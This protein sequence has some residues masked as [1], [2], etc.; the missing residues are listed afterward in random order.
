MKSFER[1]LLLSYSGSGG[2]F[3]RATS[4]A[5]FELDRRYDES[6]RHRRVPRVAYLD[7]GSMDFGIR[8]PAHPRR[9]IFIPLSL[10]TQEG[11]LFMVTAAITGDGASGVAISLVKRMREIVWIAWGF[12]IGW[13]MLIT[14]KKPLPRTVQ[15]CGHQAIPSMPAMQSIHR[16][17]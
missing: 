9:D 16:A 13:R 3:S 4:L 2:R 8:R 1:E 12:A 11:A 10:G 15:T 14:S 6:I 17:M 7:M 5:F